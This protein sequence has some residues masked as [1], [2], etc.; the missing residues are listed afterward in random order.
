MLPDSKLLEGAFPY[1]ITADGN[2]WR[3]AKRLVQQFKSGRWY[4]QI[5]KEDKTKWCFDSKKL[6]DS[7]F[8][9]QE[10]LVLTEEAV[11]GSPY[12]AMPI[13]D[14]PRYA[15]NSWGSVFCIKPP[16]RGPNAGSVYRVKESYNNGKAY[17]TLSNGG[18]SRFIS[19][20]D[21]LLL[22]KET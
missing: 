7:L 15:V 12:H 13:P 14:Y 20:D 21:V 4:A 17:V 19:V 5:Y 3:G 8:Q 10:P 22:L 9:N 1:S 16:K 2:V 6:A 11:L 18:K